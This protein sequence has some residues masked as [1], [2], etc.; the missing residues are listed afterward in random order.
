MIDQ[1]SLARAA[2]RLS[3]TYHQVRE[4]LLRG[5]LHGGVDGNGRFWVDAS[6]VERLLSQRS[7]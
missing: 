7:H 4:L 2:L 6:D 3:L 5:R 1:L